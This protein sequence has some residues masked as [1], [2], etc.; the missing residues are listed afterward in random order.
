MLRITV[1]S[2]LIAVFIFIFWSIKQKNIDNFSVAVR[3]FLPTM[4]FAFVFLGLYDIE[5]K[6]EIAQ[7]Y[8]QYKRLQ[9]E[10]GIMAIPAQ[11][12]EG[13][14]N[15]PPNS[16]VTESDDGIRLIAPP[17]KFFT[18]GTFKLTSL[19][20]ATARIRIKPEDVFEGFPEMVDVNGVGCWIKRD[21][22]LVRHKTGAA[23]RDFNVFSVRS[24]VPNQLKLYI[25]DKAIPAFKGLRVDFYPSLESYTESRQNFVWYKDHIPK[26]EPFI[27]AYGTFDLF[28]QT[29]LYR[30]KLNIWQGI[31]A[32]M[33]GNV[34]LIRGE[35]ST[36]H[37]QDCSSG[38]TPQNPSYYKFGQCEYPQNVEAYLVNF[39]DGMA[40]WH[41]KI[42]NRVTQYGEKKDV[43]LI[44][45]ECE[46]QRLPY[47]I[48]S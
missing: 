39:K 33:N 15:I 24:C 19:K 21:I 10:N 12:L 4:L 5:V 22:V 32:D 42:G 2:L 16:V 27:E 29:P 8:Q 44:T 18:W 7:K 11:M 14:D 9:S 47:F 35:L 17:G 40:D 1:Y 20:L 43:K 45:P 41:F 36:C 28:A 6:Q 23:E 37:K 25:E 30:L 48:K 31:I 3:T 26:T 13:I 34:R 46:V 38:I